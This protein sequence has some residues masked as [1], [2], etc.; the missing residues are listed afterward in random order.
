[1]ARIYK[2]K[3]E[4]FDKTNHQYD[5]YFKNLVYSGVLIVGRNG[6]IYN[7]RTKKYIAKCNDSKRYCVIG[8][9]ENKKTSFILAHRLVWIIFVGPTGNKIINHKNG[10]KNDN[11]LENL[12]LLTESENQKHAFATGLNIVSESSRQASRKRMIENNPIKIKSGLTEEDVRNIRK[13][14]TPYKRG[15]DLKISIKYGV[16]RE[17]IS[18]IRRFKIYKW[19]V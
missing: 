14:L 15:A 3:E 18:A 16:S 4:G 13:S 17:L 5:E 6:K 2:T 1:M 8:F 7:N 9:S 11:R 19:I 10:I 12:E